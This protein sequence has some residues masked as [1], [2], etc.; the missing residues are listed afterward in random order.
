[1]V[2]LPVRLSTSMTTRPC[3]VASLTFQTAR[4]CRSSD[5][6]SITRL[7]G[8]VARAIRL[9]SALVMCLVTDDTAAADPA[10]GCPPAAADATPIAMVAAIAAVAAPMPMF[11][12]LLMCRTPLRGLSYLKR[13]RPAAIAAC[14]ANAN[15]GLS[16]RRVL[17]GSPRRVLP[18]SPRRVLP[19]SPRRAELDDDQAAGRAV[20]NGQRPAGRLGRLPGD[21]QAKPGRPAAAGTAPDR[22]AAGEPGAGVLDADH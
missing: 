17:P 5:S 14:C 21:I 6:T 16:F 7:C 10:A 22:V 8:T 4:S 12:F 18:G 19:G 3:G 2:A 13:M 9:A 20:A 1:M 15:S 11:S